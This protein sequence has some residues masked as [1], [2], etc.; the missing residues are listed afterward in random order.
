M[1]NLKTNPKPSMLLLATI[2]FCLSL[3]YVTHI[4][5]ATSGDQY[6]VS[7][8]QLSTAQAGGELGPGGGSNRVRHCVYAVCPG[9]FVRIDC[10]LSPGSTCTPATCA[11][12]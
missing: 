3:L 6:G 4:D 12:C 5:K 1:K 8:A 9:P 10:N 11:Y 2:V 7:L